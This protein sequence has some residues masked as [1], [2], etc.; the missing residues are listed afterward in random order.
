M[1]ADPAPGRPEG[2][3]A[4]G[5]VAIVGAG[6]V[7]TMLGMA[8]R[9]AAAGFGVE[10]VALFD[11]DARRAAASLERGA[12]D[13]LLFGVR[14]ALA[15]EAVVLAVPV[16]QILRF[17]EEHGREA[18]PGSLLIDTGS[19]KAAVV[20]AMRRCVGPEVRALGGHPIAGTERPGPGG[21]DP[22]LLRGAAFVL[23]PVRD[24]P[25]ALARGRS[26]ARAVGARPVEMD[27]AAH[28]RVAARTSHLPHLMAAALALVVQQAGGE[29]RDLAGTGYRGAVRLASSDPH[30][31]AGF[32]WANAG[33]VRAALDDLEAALA[34]LR[35][36]LD[37]GPDHL[38]RAL[39]AARSA[40]E[41]GGGSG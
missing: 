8:L 16:P 34:G 17:L 26:L 6:Q 33:E 40:A 29:A 27:A 11:R 9:R 3:E 15:R 19:A 24:D 14:E 21:A 38:A 1:T 39:S 41:A 13:L 32:L 12:G 20:E 22:G 18:R 2:G 36:A 25:E 7:G 10:E 5:R 31:A 37:G 28:D 4:I 35:A 30:M 23:T